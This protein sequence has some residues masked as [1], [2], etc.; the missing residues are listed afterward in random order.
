M[1]WITA[2]Q[3]NGKYCILITIADQIIYDNL[4]EEEF[5]NAFVERASERAKDNAQRELN[6]IKRVDSNFDEIKGGFY[7]DSDQEV[8]NI[9]QWLKD[10]GDPDWDKYDYEITE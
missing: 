4:T 3:P 9:R 5:V 6:Y 8:E 2:R 10:V 1:G 7:P